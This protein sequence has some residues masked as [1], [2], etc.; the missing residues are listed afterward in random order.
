ME[1]EST[2]EKMSRQTQNE[3]DRYQERHAGNG[4]ENRRCSEERIFKEENT[5]T[6]T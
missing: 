1:N 3:M 4:S 6:P 2:R 5:G